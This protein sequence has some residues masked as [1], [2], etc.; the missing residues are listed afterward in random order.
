MRE[1]SVE[2]KELCFSA[3]DGTASAGQIM[4]LSEGAGKGCFTA[5]L[6]CCLNISAVIDCRAI[7][8]NLDG[9][10]PLYEQAIFYSG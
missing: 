9:A 2:Q 8:A 7:F 10:I 3:L 1:E 6:E 4:Q 5:L